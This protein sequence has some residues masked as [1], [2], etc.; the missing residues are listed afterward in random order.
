MTDLI[1][2]L[3][4]KNLKLITYHVNEEWMDIGTENDY[5]DA[6]IFITIKNYEKKTTMCHYGKKRK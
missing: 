4:T 5:I 2:K 1:G 3:L 6:N